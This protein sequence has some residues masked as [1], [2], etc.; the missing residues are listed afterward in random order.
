MG[1]AGQSVSYFSS[2][3]WKRGWSRMIPDSLTVVVEPGSSQ[4]DA[5]ESRSRNPLPPPRATR[6]R[7]LLPR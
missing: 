6:H 7:R 1:C 5:L 3:A 2:S 4:Q